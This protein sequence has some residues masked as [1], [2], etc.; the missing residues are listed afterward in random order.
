GLRFDNQVYSG[1]A[2]FNY[3]PS[4]AEDL[5]R[6]GFDVV[7]TANNHALDRGPLGIDRTLDALDAAKLRYTGTRRLGTQER[8]YTVTK[9]KGMSVAWIACTLHTNFGK[10]DADQVLDCFEPEQRVAKAVEQLA[11]D[12]KI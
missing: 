5:V 3:H 8:W 4:I 1:Y 10:D 2:K 11:R 12:P 6:T 7:S 9:A